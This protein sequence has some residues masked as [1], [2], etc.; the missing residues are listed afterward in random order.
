M[1]VAENDVAQIRHLDTHGFQSR[2]WDISFRRDLPDPI[3]APSLPDGFSLRL[4]RGMDELS[5]R[6]E[7]QYKAF[8]NTIPWQ[9]YLER[10][11]YFLRSPAYAGAL[12]VVAAAEDGQIASYCITWLDEVTREGHFEPVGTTP[13]FQGKGLGKAVLFEAMRCLQDAGMRQVSVLTSETN[14]A[15]R[16][17]YHSVGFQT[18][19]RLGCFERPQRI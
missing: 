5:C 17:L 1:W 14:L 6:A 13:N 7:V 10:F 15:A 18:I 2:Q 4:C 8:N 19:G 9:T 12:D 11:A 3:K 16:A